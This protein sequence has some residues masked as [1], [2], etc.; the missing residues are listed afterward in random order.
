M[1][2]DALRSQHD[3]YTSCSED[4]QFLIEMTHKLI[5]EMMKDGPL[6]VITLYSTNFNTSAVLKEK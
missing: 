5:K 6:Y 3:T 2:G 1:W 4:T